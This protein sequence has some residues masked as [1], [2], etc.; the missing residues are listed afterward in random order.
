M[1]F[2][3]RNSKLY[4]IFH[5]YYCLRRRLH[6][7]DFNIEQG[8]QVIVVGGRISGRPRRSRVT[9]VYFLSTEGK[10]LDVYNTTSLTWS[11]PG[12]GRFVSPELIQRAL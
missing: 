12:S 4:I 3:K 9:P 5:I 7:L 8:A 1:V 10:V 2:L 11:E 6:A